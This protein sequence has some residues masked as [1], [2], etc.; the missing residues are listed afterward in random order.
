MN[1]LVLVTRD[2]DVYSYVVEAKPKHADDSQF[3]VI[4][5]GKHTLMAAPAG[6]G[7]YAFDWDAY[8]KIDKDSLATEF[9]LVTYDRNEKRDTDIKVNFGKAATYLFNQ[10]QG[11]DGSFSFNL[12]SDF[13]KKTS[14][15]AYKM[16]VDKA[17]LLV[18]KIEWEFKPVIKKESLPPG[19]PLIKLEA[20]T[21]IQFS[22]WDETVA[23][24]IPAPIKAKWNLK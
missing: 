6:A 19:V 10:V 23:F 15:S 24:D 12:D 8:K 21:T 18:C 3:T 13:D 11:S 22:K 14:V 4:L 16:W 5:T 2:G 9:A 20:L 1:E 7:S 17:T